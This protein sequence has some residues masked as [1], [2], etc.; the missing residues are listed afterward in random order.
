MIQEGQK[1][2]AKYWG[3]FNVKKVVKL[4]QPVICHSEETG[5]AEF[6]PTIV[7]IEWEKSPSSDVNEFWMPYWMKIRGKEKYG[8]FA[9]ML[10][11][12]AL[13]QLLQEAIRRDFF[14]KE[15]MLGLSDTLKEKLE[16][17]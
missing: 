17:S 1:K 2:K 9:P 10:G 16:R 8:Q 6:T 14:T 15:F 12:N 7:Q 4:A 13:L 5:E 11:A 3:A